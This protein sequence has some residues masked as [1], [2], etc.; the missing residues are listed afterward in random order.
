MHTIFPFLTVRLSTETQNR[1]IQIALP[2]I[3]GNTYTAEELHWIVF[4]SSV[5]FGSS[6]EY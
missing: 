2:P 6:P 5:A 3:R 4:A 1:V